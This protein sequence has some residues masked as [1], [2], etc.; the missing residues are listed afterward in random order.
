VAP[1]SELIIDDA[2]GVL[3]LTLRHDGY[4][5]SFVGADDGRGDAG[6]GTCR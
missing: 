5:W 1:N 3:V 6:T 2:L 4:D